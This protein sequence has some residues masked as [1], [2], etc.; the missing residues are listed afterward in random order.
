MY[1]M[2]GG[3]FWGSLVVSLLLL[4]YAYIIWILA[5]KESGGAKLTGQIIAII[6]AVLA[7]L[8]LLYSGVYGGLLGGGMGGG[9]QI[10][11]W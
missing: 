7:I 10:R 3:M 6:V 9:C 4:G 8:I 1:A 5:A 11:I 2:V